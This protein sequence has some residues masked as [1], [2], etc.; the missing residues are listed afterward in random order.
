MKS[1]TGYGLSEYQDEKIRMVTE[2]KSYN[3]KYLDI[4]I[5][6]PP[7]L[8]PLDIE[9][10]KY[11][12][13][14]VGRG[15]VEITVRIKELEEDLAV[16]VDREAVKT[17][18]TALKEIAEE[19]EI[20]ES[21]HISHFLRLEGVIK[22]LK[23]RDMER[24]RRILFSELDRV[25]EVYEEGRQTEGKETAADIFLNLDI[26]SDSLEIIK[27]KEK[28]LE[29]IFKNNILT[30]FQEMINGDVDE[31]RVLAETA[32]LLMKYG[33]GEEINRLESHFGQFKRIAAQPGQVGKKLDFICQEINREINTIGSKSTLLEI[34][35]AVVEAK[36][37]LE[38]IREQLRNVE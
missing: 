31:N 19:A 14:R 28:E 9:T 13:N 30:R 22:T 8:S 34:S 26:L 35:H 17:Y 6:L 10:R 1:M 3:N 20:N 7:F 16:V 12:K 5:N 25:F 36:D 2:I 15:R 37:S 11:V 21:P 33:I 27:G 18:N 29:E 4:S 38:K 24:Y 32:L 23:N